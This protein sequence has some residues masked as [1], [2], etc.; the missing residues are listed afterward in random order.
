MPIPKD[1]IIVVDVS[2]SW[3]AYRIYLYLTLLYLI[4]QYKIILGKFRSI[5]HIIWASKWWD[6]LWHKKLKSTLLTFER[7]VWGYHYGVIAQLVERL[8]SMQEA[9]GSTPSNSI[10]FIHPTLNSH[11]KFNTLLK[12]MCTIP[13]YSST[14]IFYQQHFSPLLKSFQRNGIN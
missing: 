5:I 12:L 11:A 9:L 14:K 4:N 7:R 2:W 6:S 13:L 10:F 1:R 8:L 3:R